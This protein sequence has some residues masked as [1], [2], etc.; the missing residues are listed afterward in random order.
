MYKNIQ[1]LS[2]N[3]KK[4][5]NQRQKSR[6]CQ[7]ITNMS[8]IKNVKKKKVQNCQKQKKMK[9]TYVKK[10]TSFLKCKAKYPKSSNNKSSP[11]KKLQEVIGVEY[12]K[13]W[14]NLDN[15]LKRDLIYSDS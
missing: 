8:N 4:Y 3:V 14:N 5:I 10:V 11:F 7:L 9:E 6:K 13:F 1:K 15:C 2:H 12:T